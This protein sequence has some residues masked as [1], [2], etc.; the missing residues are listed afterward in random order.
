MNPQKPPLR[1][2]LVDGQDLFREAMRA[3]LDQNARF[4]VVGE[5]SNGTDAIRRALDLQPD[6]ILMDLLMSGLSG[7]EAT[8][9]I[10]AAQPKIRILMLTSI[11]ESDALLQAL[12]SGATGYALKSLPTAELQVAILTTAQGHAY[13]HPCVAGYLV[14]EYRRLAQQ[15]PTENAE[16]SKISDL[17]SQRERAI[18]RHLVRGQ[19]NKEIASSIGVTEGTVKNHLTSIFS[20]FKVID[21]TALAIKTRELGIA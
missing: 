18:L 16:A 3:V 17:L 12:R 1:I 19:S 7:I 8:R 20:K 14:A 5:A 4:E 6:V 13:L 15:Q 21:R 2:L 9:R 11:D 10:H